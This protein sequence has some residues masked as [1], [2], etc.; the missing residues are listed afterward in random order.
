[1]HRTSSHCR[2][3]NSSWVRWCA[4]WLLVVSQAAALPS[5]RVWCLVLNQAEQS[6]SESAPESGEEE[7]VGEAALLNARSGRSSIVVDQSPRLC[8]AT[9]QQRVAIVARRCAFFAELDGRNGIGG[10]LR[11]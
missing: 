9:I 3:N 8:A 1:M 5:G 11:C 7:V 4:L 10:P 2:F 6:E